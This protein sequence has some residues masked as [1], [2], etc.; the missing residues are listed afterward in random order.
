MECVVCN[1]WFSKKDCKRCQ[2][3][4]K[5]A[6]GAC[7]KNHIENKCQIKQVSSVSS[8]DI[9][10]ALLTDFFKKEKL[11]ITD[12]NI[13]NAVTACVIVGTVMRSVM[14]EIPHYKDFDL[15]FPWFGD[16]DVDISKICGENTPMLNVFNNKLQAR[17][18]IRNLVCFD[19]E[20]GF[21]NFGMFVK[22]KA[23][24]CIGFVNFQ[25]TFHDNDCVI[26]QLYILKE[27]QNKGVG[28]FLCNAVKRVYALMHQKTNAKYPTSLQL[29][30]E[31]NSIN[32]WEKQGFSRD[33]DGMPF[34]FGGCVHMQ[35]VYMEKPSV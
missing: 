2:G 15:S 21:P 16:A 35:L 20:I 7:R 17:S 32:F 12:N 22:N 25:Y 4:R 14:K 23:K 8:L 1:K 6:C 3:C 30:S 26:T 10:R 34:S 28:T 13:V 27:Y 33:Y 5:Y 18:F 9:N 31:K 19:D 24:E 29:M 11:E